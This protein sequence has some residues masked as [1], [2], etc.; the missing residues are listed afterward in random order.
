MQIYEDDYLL[1]GSYWHQPDHQNIQINV[2][3]QVDI[4]K[5]HINLSLTVCRSTVAE[6]EL[7]RKRNNRAASDNLLHNIAVVKLGIGRI[8]LTFLIIFIFVI[9]TYKYIIPA[10]SVSI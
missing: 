10:S 8:L 3:A 4:S 6:K 2:S 9:F 1:R 7:L 5:K